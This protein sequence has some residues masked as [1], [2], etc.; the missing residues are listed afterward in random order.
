MPV[1][2]TKVSD[3]GKEEHFIVN[4]EMGVFQG[5]VTAEGDSTGRSARPNLDFLESHKDEI[6]EKIQECTDL[7]LK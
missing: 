2:V 3:L 6:R 5:T 4:D 1:E 7:K